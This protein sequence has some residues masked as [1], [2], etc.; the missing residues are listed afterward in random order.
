MKL[1]DVLDKAGYVAP[2]KPT[3]EPRV[4][5]RRT[6]NLGDLF[7]KADEAK[8]GLPRRPL[9]LQEE[10]PRGAGAEEFTGTLIPPH[11]ILVRRG[12]DGEVTGTT[13]YLRVTARIATVEAELRKFRRLRTIR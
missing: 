1:K 10:K 8:L 11:R 6:V 13:T 5:N 3:P 7:A 4:R 9:A 2:P 12:K